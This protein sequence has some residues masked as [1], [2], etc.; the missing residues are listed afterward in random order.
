M[1]LKSGII[2][3]VV[4][5]ADF[6]TSVSV[7]GLFSEK[8]YLRI[9][10]ENNTDIFGFLCLIGRHKK[11]SNKVGRYTPL[12]RQFWRLRTQRGGNA[13]SSSY[14]FGKSNSGCLTCYSMPGEDD[15]NSFVFPNRLIITE[16][17]R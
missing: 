4:F 16:A 6:K 7:C 5:S 15:K 13:L 2:Q 10:N 17:A 14:L 8:V 11:D 1:K 9:W 3:D 12:I